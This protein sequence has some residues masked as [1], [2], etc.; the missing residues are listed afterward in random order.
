VDD[1]Y[2]VLGQIFPA[3][4]GSVRWCI[5]CCLDAAAGSFD[6]KVWVEVFARIDAV[7]IKRHSSMQN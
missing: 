6:T 1:S 3:D 4:K 5:V 2:V 7:A